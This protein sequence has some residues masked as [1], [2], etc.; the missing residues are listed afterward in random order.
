MEKGEYIGYAFWPLTLVQPKVSYED[1]PYKIDL[2]K[3]HQKLVDMFAKGDEETYRLQSQ[4]GTP[5]FNPHLIKGKPIKI[6]VLGLDCYTFPTDRPFG[7]R[8]IILTGCSQFNYVALA[9]YKR[10]FEETQKS[11]PIMRAGVAA[12]VAA[13]ADHPLLHKILTHI[14]KQTESYLAKME[15]AATYMEKQVWPDKAGFKPQYEDIPGIG[16]RLLEIRIPKDVD[17]HVKTEKKLTPKEKRLL[18]KQERQ[19]EKE[20]KKQQRQRDKEKTC[21]GWR[22]SRT[23][24]ACPFSRA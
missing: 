16:D 11:F 13:Q 6:D 22:R 3:D 7:I 12:E 4:M 21:L 15:H 24:L 5:V 20:L 8:I 18:K 23:W 9:A 17:D 14:Q 10:Y 19:R 1:N 2:E